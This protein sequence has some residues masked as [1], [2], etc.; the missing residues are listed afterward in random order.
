MMGNNAVNLPELRDERRVNRELQAEVS[1]MA[2]E[3]RSDVVTE[4]N[5]R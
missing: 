3:P 2:Q 5:V 4:A 1:T